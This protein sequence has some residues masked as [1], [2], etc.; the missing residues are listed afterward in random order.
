MV[1]PAKFLSYDLNHFSPSQANIP[2]DQYVY[3]YLYCSQE[4]RRAFKTTAKMH[5]GNQVGYGIEKWLTLGEEYRPKTM[6]T[7]LTSDPKE[8]EQHQQNAQG[9]QET[10]LNVYRGLKE[11]GVN[12]DI[13]K[14][15]EQ[16]VSGEFEGVHIP[17]IGRTDIETKRFVVELKTK[18]RVRGAM[19]KDG[20]RSYSRSR[21][22]EKPDINHLKQLAFYHTFKP[23][24]KSFLLYVCEREEN[25]Y[26]IFDIEEHDPKQLMHEFRQKLIVKQNVAMCEDP[27]SFVEPDFSHYGWNI[28]DEY[29]NKA[30]E[31][32]GFTKK[33]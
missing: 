14:R 4:E 13:D 28:G 12:D 19:K 17:V 33:N 11:I 24:V 3:K 21:L 30:K 6:S 7:F 26:K 1:I 25:G 9:F 31:Y 22:P 23:K 18:W 10:L 29:L 32:Y 2:L 27:R 15:F 20:T 16:Y 8:T 5:A